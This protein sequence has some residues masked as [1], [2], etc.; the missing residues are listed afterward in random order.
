MQSMEKIVSI[1]FFYKKGKSH[2]LLQFRALLSSYDV[3]LDSRNG[4]EFL[5]FH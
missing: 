5:D 2:Q 4:I 3:L 1:F